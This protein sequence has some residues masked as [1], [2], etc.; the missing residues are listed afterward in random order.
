VNL[1]VVRHAIA[2]VR[3]PAAWPDDDARPLTERGI[4]RFRKAALGLER[5]VPE[6][7][8]VL[9]SPKARAWD[10]AVILNEEA[11]WPEPV[12]CDAL[13]E[14][15]PLAV[16]QALEPYAEIGSLA[17][18]GH[19]PY[20]GRLIAFLLRAEAG[21]AFELRKGGA[22][23]LYLEGLTETSLSTLKWFLTPKVLRALA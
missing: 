10:T 13:Q 15:E 2:E 19:E 23:S 3:D 8:L 9:S 18:V 12:A 11:G 6:V 22:A 14:S 4:R 17:L 5:L 1:Y 16:L 20:L 21:P 7:D